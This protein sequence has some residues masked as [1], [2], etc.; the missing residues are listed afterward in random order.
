MP[1]IKP[2]TIITAKMEKDQDKPIA[3]AITS[4]KKKRTDPNSQ[5]VAVINEVADDL[6]DSLNNSGSTNHGIGATPIE[7]N[8]L[9]RIKQIIG[10]IGLQ[11]HLALQAQRA[12]TTA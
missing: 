6:T 5:L 8:R 1:N 7:N 12:N 10:I 4:H 3:D 11:F 2:N 9:S